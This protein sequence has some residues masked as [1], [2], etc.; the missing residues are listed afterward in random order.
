MARKGLDGFDPLRLRMLT[1]FHCWLRN[2]PYPEP[3][4][5]EVSVLDDLFGSP[6]PWQT[7][8]YWRVRHAGQVLRDG[9]KDAWR[10][11]KWFVQRGRRGWSDRD[12]WSLDSYLAEWLPDALRALKERKHGV[13]MEMFDEGS[14][15][16]PEATEIAVKRWNATLDQMIEGFVAWQRITDG[17][18]EAELGE[19]PLR[20]PE[21][22]SREAWAAERTR[23]FMRC[24]ELL[25]RDQKLFEAGMAL[26]SKHWGSLWD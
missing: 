23:R 6:D 4:T 15:Y 9:P 25:A 2:V 18:Y 5:Y 19:Y 13:P 20:R 17:L 7:R 10:A 12:L 8:W 24:D 1:R 11:V 3:E 22:V 21:H 16:S 26:F 14:D